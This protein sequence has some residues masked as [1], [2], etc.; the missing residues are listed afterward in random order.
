MMAVTRTASTVGIDGHL[1]RVEVDITQGLPAFVMV[2][3][4]EGAVRE[5]RVRVT[6]AIRN[7]GY[8]LPMRKIVANLAPADLRKEGSGFDLPLAAAILGSL[9]HVHQGRF[10]GWAL[11]GELSLDGDLRPVTGIFPIALACR[12]AGLEGIVVPRANAAEAALVKGLQVRG[13]ERLREVAEFLNGTGELPAAD[14]PLAAAPDP[15]GEDLRDVAGQLAARRALEI[16]AAGGHNL[17]LTGPPGAG[18]SML[19]RRLPGILPPLEEQER[20]ETTK[21]WS[22]AGLLD[23]ASP[24]VTRPP[25]RAPH[26]TITSPAMAGGGGIPRPG[27]V[28]LAHNG[29]L[30][31]DEFPEFSSRILETL[32]QP[33]EEGR[34]LLVRSVQTHLFPA[35]FM[36][37]AAMNP[38]P[39]GW[40]GHPVR[41]CTC[42]PLQ[43]KRYRDRISG[44]LLDR[45][46]L[47]VEVPA[48]EVDALERGEGEPSAA[49]ALRVAAA[50]QRAR[51][52]LAGLTARRDA[53]PGPEPRLNAALGPAHLRRLPA[54]E[55]EA[56]S[57]LAR[58]ARAYHLSART[59]HRLLKVAWTI[60]DLDASPILRAPHMSEALHYR[61][62]ER[63]GVTT[64][65][66][67]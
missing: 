35:R 67:E 65:A 26:H 61:M 24:L 33:I 28:S 38:C 58:A 30:F 15:A 53:V 8:V 1:I 66:R 12:L 20:L 4:A 19:A 13:A 60:A 59:Y 11:A 32:R 46:D 43:V 39:C 17:L 42:T 51:E 9:G 7:A 37:V 62:G 55:E 45:I 25:F 29:V 22:V 57:L 64:G 23:P 5:S 63:E 16:A 50:R 49:V 52:R 47:H 27:E 34:I 10:E 14:L 54:P 2:G 18:K 36:L 41:P 6:S 21:V 56:R 31:L 3:L 44:P 48:V 40:R